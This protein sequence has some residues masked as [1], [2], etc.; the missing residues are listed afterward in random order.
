MIKKSRS[1]L[2]NN[3][4]VLDIVKTYK[5]ASVVHQMLIKNRIKNPHTKK[6][7]VITTVRNLIKKLNSL[8]PSDNSII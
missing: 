1:Y 8:S 7:Y 6:P 4:K 3:P 5:D 2:I